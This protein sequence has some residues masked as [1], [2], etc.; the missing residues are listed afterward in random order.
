MW[1]EDLTGLDSDRPAHV[2]AN[3][4]LDGQFLTSQGN[5]RRMQAGILTTPALA[6]LRAATPAPVPGGKIKA[7][8]II[9]DA[10]ALHRD[11]AN[12]GASFQ[13]ASQFNLLEMVSPNVSPEAGI[14]R[15]EYD[16][17]QGPA[18]AIACGAGTLYRNYLV[19]LNGQTGQSD[20]NQID[21]LADLGAALGNSEN[22]LWQMQNGYALPIEAGLAQVTETL[23]AASAAALDRLAGLLRVGV[24]SDTE[25]TITPGGH[26]VTQIYAS[27]LPMRYSHLRDETF[28]PFAR[29]VL[30]AAYEATLRAALIASAKSGNQ[31]LYLTLLG[32]GAFGNRTEWIVDAIERALTLLSDHDLDVYIVSYSRPSPEIDAMI[33]RL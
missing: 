30:N 18:C 29:L 24:Q 28:E 5:N 7:R 2:R 15:Y 1:F 8:Q 10:Q 32:G 13:A 27:A 21:C 20:S 26:L 16:H 19:P 4:T 33:A 17:T 6:E 22:Q 3:V 25:V 23:N 11:P 12:A 9:A 31:H 14:A